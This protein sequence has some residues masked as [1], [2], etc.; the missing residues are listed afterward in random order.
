MQ[1]FQILIDIWNLIII[2]PMINSLVLLYSIF[3]LNFGIAIIAF[4]LI[5]TRYP[6]TL[7]GAPEPPDDED[8]IASAS[9]QGVAGKTQGR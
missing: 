4:T 6:H 7:D 9:A 5:I 3:F 1:I 2:Q 8:D